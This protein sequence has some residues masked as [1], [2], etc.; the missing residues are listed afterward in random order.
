MQACHTQILALHNT[1]RTKIIWWN[2]ENQGW[3]S[4]LWTTQIMAWIVQNQQDKLNFNAYT[5]YCLLQKPPAHDISQ[6]YHFTTSQQSLL[7][8]IHLSKC[9]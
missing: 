1:T 5:I 6:L 9:F 3:I 7:Y 8:G 2:Q 4:H